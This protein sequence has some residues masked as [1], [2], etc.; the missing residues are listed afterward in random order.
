[1]KNLQDKLKEKL[2]LLSSGDKKLIF[3]KNDANVEITRLADAMNK[4]KKYKSLVLLDPF[5][6]QIN[7]ESITSL[8]DTATDLWILIPSGVV[9][10]RLLDRKGELK[11]INKLTSFFGLSEIEIRNKFYRKTKSNTL[12]GEV[13]RIKKVETP[14]KIIA[15]TYIN[16]L[17]EIF[18][19]VTKKP[20]VLRNTRNFPIYHFAFASNNKNAVKIAK[21]IIEK[22]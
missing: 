9:I 13:N 8:K 17:N 6:M 16:K 12:F 14:I 20:L 4:N 18:K 10:N 2:S 21:Q 15:E 1:M 3:R 22:K 7:W 19:F 11:S 5:G